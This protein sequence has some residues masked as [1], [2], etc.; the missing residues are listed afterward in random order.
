M[1]VTLTAVLVLA[2]AAL[3]FGCGSAKPALRAGNMPQGGSFSGVWF[4]PQYGEMHMVQNG[5]TV[6]GRYA[7]EEKTGRIQG[8]V[9]GD[10]MR[11]E[12]T[13][14]RE[15]IVGRPTT[16]KGHGY[17]RVSFD[18][19][20]KA[21]KVEGEWGNDD[22]ETGGGPWTAIRA[23]NRQPDVDGDGGSDGD[24]GGSEGG[25]DNYGGENSS[26]GE[27]SSSG[28]DDLSDL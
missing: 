21:W 6:I 1:R 2:C 22:D 7:R 27:E 26:G 5:A 10:L 9:E 20:E 13:Q 19:A 23:R 4:S 12:W 18:E 8:T 25:G 24:E 11:F 17:F 16:S 28:S 14:S 15:L 3:A